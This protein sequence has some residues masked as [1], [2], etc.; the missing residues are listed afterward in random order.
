MAYTLPSSIKPFTLDILDEDFAKFTQL[1]ELSR[2][3]PLVY[4]TTEQ[5][6]SKFGITHEWITKTKDYWLHEYDWR[7][8]EKHINL[9]PNYTIEIEGLTVHFVALFS[10]REDAVP[11]TLLHG[12]PG[13]FIEFLPMATL[14]RE[15]YSP[16][17][18]SY[19][20]I[21]PSVPGYTLS[22]GGPLDK[23]WRV[24]D[25]ARVLHTLMLELGFKRYIAHGGDVGSFLATTMAV[26]YEQCVALHLNFCPSFT[27]PEEGSSGKELSNFEKKFIERA[28]VWAGEGNGYAI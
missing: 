22:D 18:L 8:Q 17:D 11:I 4:E 5:N 28:K 24:S 20:I 16:K 10:E 25:S 9:F 2:I 19:H 12:W 27:L 26:S 7:A 13:S 14:L 3:G 23:E 6:A 1:L 21:I 15:K